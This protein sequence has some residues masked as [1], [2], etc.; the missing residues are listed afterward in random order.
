MKSQPLVSIVIPVYNGSN[1]L[2]EAIDSALNQTYKNIEIIVVN[3]GSNDNGSTRDIALSYG[4][5]IR[6]FEKENGGVSTALNLAINNMKGEYFSWLSHDDVYYPRKIQASVDAVLA[7]DDRTK[8]VLCNCEFYNVENNEVMKKKYYCDNNYLKHG[9]TALLFAVFGCTLLIHRSYFEKYGLFDVSKR[10]TQDYYQWFNFYLYNDLIF[11]SENLVRI[12]QHPMQGSRIETVKS[13][14][15]NDLWIFI[16]NGVSEKALD[17]VGW[18][19]YKFL[20]VWLLT[21]G[22]SETF[23][24]ARNHVVKMMKELEY[25][26]SE[27]DVFVNNYFGETHRLVLYCAGKRLKKVAFNFHLRGIR[28]DGYS[29]SDPSKI[30]FEQFGISPLKLQSLNKETDCVIITKLNPDDVKES[31]CSLGFKHVYA[32]EDVFFELLIEIPIK[33]EFLDEY[34]KWI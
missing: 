17:V 6:Y 7:S 23:K 28:V 19:R 3:D 31:L 32:Y 29:D 14:E 20:G 11:V 30:K 12:R 4:S 1:F 9:V 33:K 34:N 10:T 22:M 16:T 5:R 15:T 27:K 24:R 26:D 18:S 13:K 8:S 25:D 2:R 21:W